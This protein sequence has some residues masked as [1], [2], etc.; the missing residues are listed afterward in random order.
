MG[1]ELSNILRRNQI[2][3]RAYEMSDFDRSPSIEVLFLYEYNLFR[4]GGCIMNFV[5]KKDMS[6]KSTTQP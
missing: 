2:L 1:S 5:K 3:R 4:D 6:A